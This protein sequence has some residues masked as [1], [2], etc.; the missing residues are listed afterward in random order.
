V[1]AIPRFVRPK[2][3]LCALKFR[4]ILEVL[5]LRD[6]QK[7]LGAIP[8]FVRPKNETVCCEIQ[9]HFGSSPPPRFTEKFLDKFSRF[10]C[11]KT[12]LFDVEF[13]PILQAFRM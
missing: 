4:R 7:V 5:C 9:T 10:M 12:Q 6:L 1:G 13:R 2:T 11:P 3:V 8:R